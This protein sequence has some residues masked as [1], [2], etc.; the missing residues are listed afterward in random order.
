[1]PAHGIADHEPQMLD[2]EPLG[3]EPIMRI[4]HVVVVVFRK[5]GLRPVGWLQRF[6]VADAVGNDDVVFRRIERLAGS[7]HLAGKGW[8]EHRRRRAAGAVQHQH[9]LAGRC[10]HG[11]VVQLQL[12]H[13]LAG[14]KLEI[15][16]DP[17]ALFGR[18]IVSRHCRSR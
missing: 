1:M 11:G 13:G 2:A 9:R 10:A 3:D 4:D 8:R 18:G 17:I 12:R 6:A 14:V 15:L 16:R 5:C 7:E